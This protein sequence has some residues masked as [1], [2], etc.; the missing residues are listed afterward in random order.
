MHTRGGPVRTE[1]PSLLFHRMAPPEAYEPAEVPIGG[2]PFAA[3]FDCEGGEIGV[4]HEIAFHVTLAAEPAEDIPM[5]GPGRDQDTVWPVAKLIG[6]R[7]CV[8]DPARL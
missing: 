8:C 5:P 3:R 1:S 2:D 7:K 6:E 4:G